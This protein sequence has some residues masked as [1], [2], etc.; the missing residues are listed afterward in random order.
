MGWEVQN[1]ALGEGDLEGASQEGAMVVGA[2]GPSGA[3]GCQGASPAVASYHRGGTVSSH[4][5]SVEV[6]SRQDSAPSRVAV[7]LEDPSQEE[8]VLSGP[9]PLVA[10]VPILQ[11]VVDFL[12]PTVHA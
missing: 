12:N 3:V 1:L 8:E 9:S 2:Q 11:A 10:G 7:A 4:S 6:A 5:H